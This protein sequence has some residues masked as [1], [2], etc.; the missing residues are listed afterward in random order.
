MNRIVEFYGHTVGTP[1]TDWARILQDENCDFTTQRCTKNRKSNSSIMI[2]TCSV[3]HGKKAPK[4]III[5]PSRLAQ[6]KKVFVA[7]LGLLTGKLPGDELH[8]IP[9]VKIAGGSVDYF[10]VAA[11]GTA[12]IDFVGIELQSLD[13]TGTI[14]PERQRLVREFGM[15]PSDDAETV[16]K[17][18]GINWKHTAKTTLMQ[19]HHKV[20]TFQ[21]VGK[22]LVLV[23][24]DCLLDYMRKEFRFSHFKDPADPAHAL[25]IHAYNLTKPQ[26]AGYALELAR[27]VSTD[28]A[29]IAQCLALQA[30]A[31]W[32][33]DDLHRVLAEK[34]KAETKIGTA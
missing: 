24:Q 25:H 2:G 23:L 15:T 16:E 31:C 10:L 6:Q 8:L 32:T 13:T 33:L 14:W 29:G 11:R 21:N 4:P 18:C 26:D 20:E 3:L 7:C 17:A 5:C 27:T 30:N 19:I 34:M 9:E 28:M 22:K 12:I 1:A